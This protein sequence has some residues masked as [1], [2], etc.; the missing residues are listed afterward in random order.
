M[1]PWVSHTLLNTKKKKGAK[2]GSL[3][4]ARKWR[5]ETLGPLGTAALVPVLRGDLRLLPRH[6]VT[7]RNAQCYAERRPVRQRQRLWH[8]DPQQ[9]TGNNKKNGPK[10]CTLF[11][12]T[13]M[14]S[15][16]PP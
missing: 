14:P 1:V 13:P 16:T 15:R 8:L 12:K 4:K 3:V 11:P 7:T 6:P 10:R 9:R 2:K 5:A